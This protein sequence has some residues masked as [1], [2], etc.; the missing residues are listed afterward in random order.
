MCTKIALTIYNTE[1]IADL[2]DN[3]FALITVNIVTL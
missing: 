3:V 1:K 2:V